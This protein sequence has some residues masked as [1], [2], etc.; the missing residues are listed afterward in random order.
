M[1]LRFGDVTRRIGF[2]DFMCCMLRLETMTCESWHLGLGL[3]KGQG[4]FITGEPAKPDRAVKGSK[5]KSA[6]RSNAGLQISMEIMN[7]QK[8]RHGPG[9]PLGRLFAKSQVL[10]LPKG[11]TSVVLEKRAGNT[12]MGALKRVRKKG[13]PPGSHQIPSEHL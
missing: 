11:E 5:G 9:I 7:C 3:G 6:G 2:S 4:S 12:A 8:S 13:W 10:L 1:S